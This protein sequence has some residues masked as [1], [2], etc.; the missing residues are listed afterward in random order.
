MQITIK[1]TEEVDLKGK[2]ERHYENKG[3][4][5]DDEE[6]DCKVEVTCMR[7]L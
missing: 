2:E 6:G 4:G 3:Y 1:N 7:T 5:E